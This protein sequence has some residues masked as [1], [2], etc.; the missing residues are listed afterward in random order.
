M[1][2][3]AHNSLHQDHSL[4]RAAITTVTVV[5]CPY[6][7]GDWWIGE[8]VAHTVAIVAPGVIASHDEDPRR[9][10]WR[11]VRWPAGAEGPPADA[12]PQVVEVGEVLALL[13]AR[14]HDR[15]RAACRTHL[16][17]LH[18]YSTSIGGRPDEDRARHAA[19]FL[20]RVHREL[21]AAF[22][23]E[24][25]HAESPTVFEDVPDTAADF[26][27][28]VERAGAPLGRAERGFER[29]QRLYWAMV[30]TY[31]DARHFGARSHQALRAHV[32]GDRPPND[33]QQT[34]EHPCV[35]G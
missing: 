16:E 24:P 34:D 21:R 28:Q 6:G 22:P 3:D 29:L 7:P 35:A 18:R 23:H 1:H 9:S 32:R 13:D 4:P 2:P 31:R 5:P 10:R 14:Q 19:Q 8:T 17:Q 20:S 25:W 26:L 33:R 11:T 12:V 15:L 30:H 27:H